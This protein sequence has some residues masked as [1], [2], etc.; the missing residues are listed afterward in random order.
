METPWYLRCGNHS[1]CKRNTQGMVSSSGPAGAQMLWLHACLKDG[2]YQ[3]NH[4]RRDH[5]C[6]R[7]L[8]HSTRWRDGTG[9][10]K[11]VCCHQH[12]ALQCSERLTVIAVIVPY[13]SNS[14][15]I[16]SGVMENGSPPANILGAGSRG[17][18]APPLSCLLS[19]LRS[20]YDIVL[21]LAC[22]R[23]LALRS[24]KHR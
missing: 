21:S 3:T 5:G 24:Q 6:P 22:K 19:P 7:A 11:V 18:S 23:L 9:L 12:A 14:V 16:S 4:Q 8:L 13:P 10:S 1:R 15:L 17:A 2:Y 20:L